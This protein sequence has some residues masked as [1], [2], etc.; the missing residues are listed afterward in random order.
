MNL[1]MSSKRKYPIPDLWVN[2]SGGLRPV[3]L[4]MS[5][6]GSPRLIEQFKS[7]RYSYSVFSPTLFGG[8]GGG[9]R[10]IYIYIYILFP[11]KQLP[12]LLVGAKSPGEQQDDLSLSPSSFGLEARLSWQPV[13]HVFFSS[14]PCF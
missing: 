13:F 3:V 14:G 8:V 6:Q 11:K 5:C 12:L 10:L 2:Q 1:R 4:D 9:A 7:G